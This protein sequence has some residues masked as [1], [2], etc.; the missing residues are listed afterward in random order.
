MRVLKTYD[1][2][3]SKIDVLDFKEDERLTQLEQLPNLIL[4]AI[5]VVT[6]KEVKIY[7]KIYEVTGSFTKTEFKVDKFKLKIT[8]ILDEILDSNLF[9][10]KLRIIQSPLDVINPVDKIFQKSLIADSLNKSDFIYKEYST[11]NVKSGVSLELN[12]TD[13][14]Y[15]LLLSSNL[16]KNKRP[17]VKG[18][19]KIKGEDYRFVFQHRQFIN[20]YKLVEFEDL[21]DKL[22]KLKGSSVI[23]LINDLKSATFVFDEEQD[24]NPPEPSGDSKEIHFDLSQSKYY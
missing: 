15:F 7:L 2:G 6:S 17:G 18:S 16:E 10:N 24:S 8:E 13:E 19:V 4:T 20:F 21:T 9:K 3:F 23:S 12:I 11:G 14:I 1:T 5:D 22:K